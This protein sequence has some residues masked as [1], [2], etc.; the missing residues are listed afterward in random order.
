[1]DVLIAEDDLTTQVILQTLVTAWGYRAVVTSDGHEAWGVLQQPDAPKLLLLDWEMPGFSG[2]ELC[3]KLAEQT[4]ENPPYIVLLTS[5]AE[6]DRVVEGLASGAHD[7]ISKPFDKAELQARLSVGRRMLE[8]QRKLIDAQQQLAYE[9]THDALTHLLNRRAVLKALQALVSKSMSEHSSMSVALVDIDHFKRINDSYGHPMGDEVL[10][11]VAETM[12]TCLSAG[13]SLGRFGGE[14]FIVAIDS[15]PE[16]ANRLMEELRTKIS[17]TPFC[18]AD[19]TVNVTVSAGIAS[20]SGDDSLRL[21]DL[22]AAADRALYQAKAD[23]RN[24]VVLAETDLP[25]L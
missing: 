23:G 9:A 19:Q 11:R 25:L 6:T 16:G 21:D 24:Q 3:K 12:Q 18:L 7:F 4:D 14:E 8:M 22:L 20:L 13:D 5:H 17:E 1:M 2:L 10:I 15:D